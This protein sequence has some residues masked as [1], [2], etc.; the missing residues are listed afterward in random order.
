MRTECRESAA[1]MSFGKG[2]LE[3]CGTVLVEQAQQ[4]A[5]GAAEMTTVTS[6]LSEKVGCRWACDKQAV[7]MKP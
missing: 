1:A 3:Q 5:R 4:A 7:S 6:D 2:G